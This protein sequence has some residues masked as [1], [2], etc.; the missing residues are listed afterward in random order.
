MRAKYQRPVSKFASAS[1]H[2]A[3]FSSVLAIAV[4]VLHRTRLLSTPD[5]FA[6]VIICGFAALLAFLCSSIGFLSLWRVGAK[7]GKASVVG[8]FISAA[9]LAPIAVNAYKFIKLPQIYDVASDMNDI[10]AFMVAVEAPQGWLGERPMAKEADFLAI[11]K[12]YPNVLG[13][14]YEG[15]V[16]RV[17]EAVLNVA[18]NN[19]LVITAS[20]G[21]RGNVLGEDELTNKDGSD[22]QNEAKFSNLPEGDQIPVPNKRPERE[23]KNL[24]AV[25]DNDVTLQG[26]Y[27]SLILGLEYSFVIRVREEQ[28]TTFV[29][30]RVVAQYGKHDF[31]VGAHKIVDFLTALDSALPGIPGG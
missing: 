7:G 6:L 3:I 17:L 27:R 4:I 26:K 28:E 22:E 5:F 30:I 8:F 13:R 15:G 9:V 23:R 18:K 10:P 16:D 31:G 12:A 21:G 11:G 24:N 25:N 2:L 20:P 19:R 29:D 1:R 14:R